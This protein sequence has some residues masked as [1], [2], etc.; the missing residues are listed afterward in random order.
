MED[1]MA[2]RDVVVVCKIDLADDVETA[3]VAAGDT[4]HIR[5]NVPK[6][7]AQL[8]EIALL[9]PDLILVQIKVA[10][11]ANLNGLNDIK[12]VILFKDINRLKELLG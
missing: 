2:N 9:A 11:S 6:G 5:E 3:V 4:P 7:K 12:K 10:A 1:T 8:G